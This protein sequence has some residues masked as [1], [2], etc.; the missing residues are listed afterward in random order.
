MPVRALASDRV[1]L[2]EDQDGSLV[3]IDVRAESRAGV[4]KVHSYANACGGF[5]LDAP[6]H[7][8]VSACLGESPEGYSA[9]EPR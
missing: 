2:G 9:F 3:V 1:L 8:V 5:A 6:V 4:Q 7:G